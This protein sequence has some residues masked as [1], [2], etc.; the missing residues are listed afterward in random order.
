M[1]DPSIPASYPKPYQT[2]PIHI[3]ENLPEDVDPDQVYC[4]EK[5]EHFYLR[6]I[7]TR[8]YQQKGEDL[9]Y[10]KLFHNR[11]IHA[12]PDLPLTK[13]MD[14]VRVIRALAVATKPKSLTDWHHNS[15]KLHIHNISREATSGSRLSRRNIPVASPIQETSSQASFR[16]TTPVQE[17]R[18]EPTQEQDPNQE[19]PDD[20][21]PSADTMLTNP[22]N[23]G[24]KGPAMAK[25]TPF[26][27]SRK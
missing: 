3:F 7:L 23:N 24:S 20:L 11:E 12:G 6:G 13:L 25:P 27:G 5:N 17:P 26:D 21:E 18:E 16:T 10:Q 2:N 22:G 14:L 1:I 19:P 15:P 8:F 9:W 4:N